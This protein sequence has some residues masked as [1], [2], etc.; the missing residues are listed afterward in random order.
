MKLLGK[1]GLNELIVMIDSGATNNCISNQVVHRLGLHCE[2]CE[3]FGVMLRNGEEI[4]GQGI[5]RRDSNPGIDNNPRVS[6]CGVG[7]FRLATRSTVVGN[8]GPD[9]DQS[10]NS[11]DAIC[12]ARERSYACWGSIS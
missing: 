1:I 9:N 5:C 3:K 6:F 12:L 7:K 11:D 8:F 2:N 4:V 10:E